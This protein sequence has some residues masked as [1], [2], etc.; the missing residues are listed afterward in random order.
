MGIVDF[1]VT[2]ES[3][4]M[5]GNTHTFLSLLMQHTETYV[6]QDAGFSCKIE[7]YVELVGCGSVFNVCVTSDERRAV[8]SLI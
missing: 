8:V 3:K 4:R 6:L 5:A 1:S 2:L 7:Q